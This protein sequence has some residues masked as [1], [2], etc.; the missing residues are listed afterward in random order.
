MSISEYLAYEECSPVRHEYVDGELYA[1]AGTT[2]RHNRIAGNIYRFFGESGERM[3]CDVIIIDVKLQV[4]SNVIYYP[5]LM[6]VCDP[7]DTDP[8]IKTLPCVV[9]EVLSDST[10][11]IDM[12]EKAMMYRQ[13]DSLDVYLI[14]EP[15]ERKVYRHWRDDERLWWSD[16]V[17]HDRPIPIP[18][19]GIDLSLD[20]IYRNLP[21]VDAS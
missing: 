6:V 10:R 12:R 19:L 2:V 7:R 14:I 5:D 13:V 11:S 8:L 17:T 18:C 21:P 4:A 3:E 15:D 20:D 1:F 16:T 9:V